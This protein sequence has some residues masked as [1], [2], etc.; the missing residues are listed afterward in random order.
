MNVKQIPVS[1]DVI[2]HMG[3]FFV[4][5]KLASVSVVKHDAQVCYGFN[6]YWGELT[7]YHL[8]R[9]ESFLKPEMKPEV[10][11]SS[12]QK[13]ETRQQNRVKTTGI[14]PKR[15]KFLQLFV[16]PLLLIIYVDIQ[17]IFKLLKTDVN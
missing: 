17:F 1:P 6:N 2:T 9:K 5:V 10:K 7:V 13:L 11:L 3:R 4:N 8:I 14:K 16:L 12:V 15:R